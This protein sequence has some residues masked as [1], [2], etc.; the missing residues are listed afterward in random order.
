MICT[1]VNANK[2]N[3][4]VLDRT[5]IIQKQYFK[6]LN[7]TTN[8]KTYLYCLAALICPLLYFLNGFSYVA[9]QVTH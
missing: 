7:A 6:L 5:E 9:C 4:E 8:T 3:A 2:M 1:L